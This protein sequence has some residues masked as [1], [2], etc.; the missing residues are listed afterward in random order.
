MTGADDTGSDLAPSAREYTGDGREG[1]SEEDDDD[2][3][4]DDDND[5]DDDDNDEDVDE[6]LRRYA[7]SGF[8]DP[9]GGGFPTSH[10]GPGLPVALSMLGGMLSM[11]GMGSRLREI[12]ANLR[13]K[14]D[15]S[16]QLI[17]LQDLSEILLVSNEENLIGSFSPDPYV[18]ELVSLMQPNEMTGEENPEIISSPPA[19]SE[20]P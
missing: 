3:D 10:R 13:R 19:L 4:D 18:R 2:G 14:E 12:L 20:L 7:E 15:P 5:D 16:V 6:D 8:G 11:S 9:F 1:I 17:A